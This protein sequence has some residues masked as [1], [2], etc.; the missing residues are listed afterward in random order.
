LHYDIINDTLKC[1]AY[2]VDVTGEQ[3]QSSDGV[4]A[5]IGVISDSLDFGSFPLGGGD[6]SPVSITVNAQGLINPLT[7]TSSNPVF[8]L[9]TSPKFPNPVQTVE[10]SPD[11]FGNVQVTLYVGIETSQ[12]GVFNSEITVSSFITPTTAVTRTLFAKGTRYNQFGGAGDFGIVPLNYDGSTLDSISVNLFSAVKKGTE[13]E[14][15][16][17]LTGRVTVVTVRE[18]A[19]AGVGILL[20]EAQVLELYENSV[21]RGSTAYQG[22]GIYV[23]ENQIV[24][25]VNSDGKVAQIALGV[26][27]AVGSVIDISADQVKIND[28]I[29]TQGVGTD[30]G[31][32]ATSDYDPGLDGWK[33]DGDGSAE[34]NNVVARGTV[35]G[36]SGADRYELN[37]ST[38]ITLGVAGSYTSS[39]SGDELIFDTS[40]SVDANTP[41]VTLKGSDISARYGNMRFRWLATD[42][43][44]ATL[45]LLDG[46][47]PRITLNNNG[48]ATLKGAKINFANLPTSDSGLT[49]GD[50]WRDGN[51]VKVKT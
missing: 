22:T 1:K 9:S 33:I 50:L 41:Q 10:V 34:F 42:A 17:S 36:G 44:N 27:D 20:I 16:D 32:I 6:T 30:P 5:V 45:Q 26:E 14:I 48:D 31:N 25:K 19:P 47:D 40:A 3:A 12:A 18:D 2:Q 29:F 11:A 51:T 35:I 21:I 15:V 8:V 28:I 7:V 24:L 4:P 43:N 46:T 23:A 39:L 13:L 49:V 37:P 38:G